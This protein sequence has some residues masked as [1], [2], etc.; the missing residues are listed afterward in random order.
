MVSKGCSLFF[1]NCDSFK[2]S[3]QQNAK[4]EADIGAGLSYFGGNTVINSW[5]SGID[6]LA[7]CLFWRKFGRVKN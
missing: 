7:H 6:L 3:V 2:Y 1:L 4:R 5:N